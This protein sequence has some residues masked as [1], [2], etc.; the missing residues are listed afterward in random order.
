MDK[1]YIV[2]PAYNEEGAIAKVVD[3]WHAV[4]ES[5]GHGSK[6]VIFNDGSKDNTLNV[7]E[8]IKNKYPNL[9]SD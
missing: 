9:D 4:V 5:I 8:N 1:L 2:M 3:E 7:L 6:L